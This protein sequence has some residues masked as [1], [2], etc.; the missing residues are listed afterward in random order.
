MSQNQSISPEQKR[1]FEQSRD[2]VHNWAATNVPTQLA[3]NSRATY[4]ASARNAQIITEEQYDFAS[5]YYGNLWCYT[6]D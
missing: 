6:G 3:Y 1:M 4:W 2:L 5:S